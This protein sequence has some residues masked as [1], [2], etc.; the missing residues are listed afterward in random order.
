[1]SLENKTSIGV[2]IANK[3]LEG[4]SRAADGNPA[5]RFVVRNGVAYPISYLTSLK[6]NDE[7][8]FGD[9]KKAEELDELNQRAQKAIDDL[10]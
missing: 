5:T 10:K 8:N 3:L 7:A 1:M 9:P 2:R 6:A 4:V